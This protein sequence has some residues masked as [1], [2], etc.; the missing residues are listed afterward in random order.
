MDLK[1]V[2]QTL[3]LILLTELDAFYFNVTKDTFKDNTT[4][5]TE[6]SIFTFIWHRDALHDL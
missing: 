3:L 1:L 4:L 6:E 5:Q 2:E